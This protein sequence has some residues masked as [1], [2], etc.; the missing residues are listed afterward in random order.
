[1]GTCFSKKQESSAPVAAALVL[2]KAAAVA[3]EKSGTKTVHRKV[4]DEQSFVKKEIFI[5][6]HRRSHSHGSDKQIQ[7]Q[8]LSPESHSRADQL[9]F[10]TPVRTSSCTREE[11]DA[12]LIQCGR[13][14]R[15]SSAN[16]TPSGK[17]SSGAKRSFDFDN[18]DDDE[19]RRL[20]SRSA[21]SSPSK[22][23]RRRTPSRERTLVSRRVSRS[24]GRRSEVPAVGAGGVENGGG[25]PGKMVSVPA[26]VSSSISGGN[27][28][29]SSVRRIAVR[30]DVRSPRS[31]SP[32]QNLQPLILSRS[33][34]RK[35]DQSPHRRNPLSETDNNHSCQ[36]QVL[37]LS[38]EFITIFVTCFCCIRT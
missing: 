13:L 24:P 29:G 3:T 15:S 14:S 2:S 10:G 6:K 37:F 34:S 38:N 32:A 25:R 18:E 5:I 11:V 20:D 31:Q 4:E 17:K 33:N 30:R 27:D 22:T 23:G 1:M 21:R 36:V 26:S 19:A 9:G 7:I 28:Q 8:K 12:I 35:T 16:I